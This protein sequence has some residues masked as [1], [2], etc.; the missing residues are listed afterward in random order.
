MKRYR[1]VLLNLIRSRFQ[2]SRS[3]IGAEI[4]VWRGHTSELL[5][6]HL[7]DLSLLAVD[8]WEK[9]AG[10]LTE[11]VPIDMLQD[12]H[13][14]FLQRTA[15]FQ[16]RCLIF[17]MASVIAAQRVAYRSLN[18]VFIDADHCYDHVMADL[19]AWYP[20]LKGGGLFC[21]H[22]YDNVHD[23]RGIFGVKRAVN[24][25]AQR[26]SLRCVVHPGTIWQLMEKSRSPSQRRF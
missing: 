22:D 8:T 4:G 21:G 14:E 18:F 20:K 16:Q 1:K 7:P 3:I 15:L 24:E 6:H 17:Q 10:P 2:G 9:L 5:L 23:R 26:H 19:T 25:F 11:P 13:N 12:A